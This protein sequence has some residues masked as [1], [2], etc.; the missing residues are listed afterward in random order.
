MND[1][2]I[3]ATKETRL[4]VGRMSSETFQLVCTAVISQAFGHK[5]DEELPVKYSVDV[6]APYHIIYCEIDTYDG[7]IIGKTD[8]IYDEDDN[9]ISIETI[10]C[11][12]VYNDK[13]IKLA[14]N[15]VNL[16]EDS[17]ANCIASLIKVDSDK[18]V[19]NAMLL[20]SAYPYGMNPI[21]C[22]NGETGNIEHICLTPYCTI[23]NEDKLLPDGFSINSRHRFEYV[24]EFEGKEYGAVFAQSLDKYGL[25]NSYMLTSNIIFCSNSANESV[26]K[27]PICSLIARGPM[28]I[29]TP[30]YVKD[31]S[32]PENCFWMFIST[33]GI[34][35]GENT[36]NSPMAFLLSK[37]NIPEAI[38]YRDGNKIIT[39]PLIPDK[40]K[41]S[42][43]EFSSGE[44][45]KTF[46][47]HIEKI[48]EF[49]ND[50]EI[51][52]D[53]HLVALKHKAQQLG[54]NKYFDGTVFK[55]QLTPSY[56]KEVLALK[57]D[58]A[59]AEK[60]PV[61]LKIKEILL[62]ILDFL[63]EF[64]KGIAEANSNR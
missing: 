54:D 7:A 59:F 37:K 42:L 22:V 29:N 19:S 25:G 36:I 40:E 14:Q 33:D 6:V 41:F 53:I 24:D 5:G 44:E 60:Y 8:L 61:L 20:S 63:K 13:A 1:N 32:Q 43:I 57:K 12:T 49:P 45:T 46:N 50:M 21:S 27:Y 35:Y 47:L 62:K 58:E 48:A 26:S 39:L 56:Q 31:E 55:E 3:L 10:S 15:Q 11:N 23:Q 18:G 64:M 52:S 38:I 4:Q 2:H 17:V 16:I 28:K 34:I 9:V 51:I 30:L